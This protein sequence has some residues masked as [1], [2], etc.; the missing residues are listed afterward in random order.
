MR[1][2]APRRLSRAMI[3]PFLAVQLRLSIYGAPGVTRTSD[4]LVRDPGG[5]PEDAPV[6]SI[7][8]TPHGIEVCGTLRTL[9]L[10]NRLHHV[11]A[12]LALPRNSF[13]RNDRAGQ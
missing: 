13:L 5:L 4:L 11:A 12:D 2:M 7:T 10:Q 8:C 3:A 9:Q 6:D 1:E